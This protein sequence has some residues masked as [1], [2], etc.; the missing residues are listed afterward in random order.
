[1]PYLGQRVQV[2]GSGLASTILGHK[3]TVTAILDEDIV[4]QCVCVTWDNGMQAWL[5]NDFC[6]SNVGSKVF[7]PVDVTGRVY[8][9]G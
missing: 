7:E 9:Q 4:E 5:T 2:V 3:G 6:T 8:D 1:M